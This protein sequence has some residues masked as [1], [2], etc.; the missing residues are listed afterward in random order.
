M[1]IKDMPGGGIILVMLLLGGRCEVITMGLL[2]GDRNDT[3]LTEGHQQ[4]ALFI[5][6]HL[7]L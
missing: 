4:T 6:Q 2:A 3:R 5:V 1:G 7:L